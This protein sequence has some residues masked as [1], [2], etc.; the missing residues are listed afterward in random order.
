MTILIMAV[1]VVYVIG[2]IAGYKTATK[3]HS[4]ALTETLLDYRPKPVA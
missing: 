3:A 1:V 4:K 2:L